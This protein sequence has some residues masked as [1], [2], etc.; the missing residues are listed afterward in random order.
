[1][2]NRPKD[3]NGNKLYITDLCRVLE[4]ALPGKKSFVK[5]EEGD[6]LL[7]SI[8]AIHGRETRSDEGN[9]L[10]IPQSGLSKSRL[11]EANRLIQ[12]ESTYGDFIRLLD[13]LQ[14]KEKLAKLP[15]VLADAG[16]KKPTK[17]KKPI[18]TEELQEKFK[19]IEL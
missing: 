5:T 7:V 15:K 18:I 16:K 10:V 14:M 2:K 8:Q 19:D 13:P 11:I 9:I 12:E 4:P 3:A 6:V 17:K 1:M